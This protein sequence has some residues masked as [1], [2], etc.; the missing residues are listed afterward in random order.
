MAGLGTKGK[1]GIVF[2]L[3]EEE[4]GLERALAESR[5][6]T[7]LK[8]GITAWQ[9]G[10]LEVYAVISGIGGRKSAE[11]TRM[12]IEDGAQW[13]VIS[14]FAAALDPIANVGDVIVAEKIISQYKDERAFYS[15]KSLLAAIPP[16]QTNPDAR[17][18]AC[19]LVSVDTVVSTVQQK[20]EIFLSTNAC[21]LDM[22]SYA[23][24]E[25]CY[26]NNIPFASVRAISDSASDSIPGSIISLLS[27]EGTLRR[28]IYI[29]SRPHIW[30]P[31]LNLRKKANLAAN[32]LSDVLSLMLLRLI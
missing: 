31:I 18:Y 16:S 1:L 30:H 5:S 11:A 8:N 23:A 6:V 17:I 25:V 12:L 29:V 4:I 32:N 14:G 13:I 22:E 28:I 24:A 10:S 3:R 20:K 2:A 19:T 27:T 9:L 26:E 15:D 21:A 7:Y